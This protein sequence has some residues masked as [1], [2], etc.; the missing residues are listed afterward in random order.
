MISNQTNTLQQSVIKAVPEQPNATY[1]E[2]DEANRK[3]K[4]AN[5]LQLYIKF[6]YNRSKV[7]VDMA[8][9][10]YQLPENKL[11]GAI[12]YIILYLS[13]AIYLKTIEYLLNLIRKLKKIQL[14]D[15]LV[16]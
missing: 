12:K 16:I 15:G 7:F 5:A 9:K 1:A 3:E 14:P 4:L 10:F 2:L 6:L 13:I 8:T 11:N